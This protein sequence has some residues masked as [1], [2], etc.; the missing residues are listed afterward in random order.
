MP[1]TMSATYIYTH[2]A[3]KNKW[4][5][6][7]YFSLL[8]SAS[9]LKKMT[10]CL[11]NYYYFH[12]LLWEFQGKSWNTQTTNVKLPK[13]IWTNINWNNLTF[14]NYRNHILKSFIQQKKEEVLTNKQKKLKL[15]YWSNY[16]K[17]IPLSQIHNKNIKRKDGKCK[18]KAPERH[19][20]HN[21]SY[22]FQNWENHQL[23][24]YAQEHQS[25]MKC[26]ISENSLNLSLQHTK[27]IY[28]TPKTITRNKCSSHQN[29]LYIVYYLCP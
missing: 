27:N 6:P 17:Q 3:I 24:S 28:N 13:L 15:H 18:Q 7:N 14:S 25:M 11:F 19:T 10:I 5:L 23:Q 16:L 22:Q 20:T 8:I 21:H 12:S 1:M 26:Q 29:V 9:I 2:G 4:K